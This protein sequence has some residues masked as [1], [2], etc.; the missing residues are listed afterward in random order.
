MTTRCALATAAGIVVTSNDQT[1]VQNP[2]SVADDAMTATL[3]WPAPT[4]GGRVPAFKE[5]LGL[6]E[7]CGVTCGVDDAALMECLTML[8]AGEA[9]ES[10]VFARGRP[11]QNGPDGRLTLQFSPNLK[12]GVEREDGSMDFRSRDFGASMVDKDSVIATLLPPE[13]GQ[14]GSDVTGAPLKAD[15]GSP[16]T[17]TAGEGVRTS[18]DGTTFY[19][20]LD[21]RGTVQ[22]GVIAV[23]EMVLIEGDVDFKTGHVDA[24][25][26]GV[27]VMGS[28]R[29][30]FNVDSGGTMIIHGNVGD[31]R[32]TSVA[33]ILVGGG[34]IHSGVSEGEVRCHA[35]VT[36]HHT[37]NARIRAS[38]DVTITHGA[39]NSNIRVRGRVFAPAD[40]GRIVGGSV[41]AAS[42]I[43][44][45]AVGSEAH[46]QTRLAVSTAQE[47]LELLEEDRADIDAR[48]AP[49]KAMLGERNIL[50]DGQNMPAALR[51]VYDALQQLENLPLGETL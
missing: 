32:V 49:L 25:S 19:A 48:S 21:G 14:V 23:H 27:E 29:S 9:V 46:V 43:V 6:I 4:E 1:V 37:Q 36:A 31:S 39:I 35:H 45:H 7:Q 33:D 50:G 18:D 8:R 17:V 34:I 26:R 30:T 20:E 42:G 16:L 2:V 3:D 15:D 51:D 44:A 47:T 38:G 24:Q 41:L 10:L 11:P 40:A 12:P 5:L 28:V 13:L 22:A